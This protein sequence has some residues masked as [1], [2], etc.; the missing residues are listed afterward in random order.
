MPSLDLLL[1]GG[2]K[3]RVLQAA[4]VLLTLVDPETEE[5]I[6]N[7]RYLDALFDVFVV[8]WTWGWFAAVIGAFLSSIWSAKNTVQYVTSGK[9]LADAMTGK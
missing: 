1:P 8:A 9:L 7:G 3:T 2:R 5:H 6:R 4:L